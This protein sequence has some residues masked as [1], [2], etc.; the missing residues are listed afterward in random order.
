MKIPFA[1]PA[2][3]QAKVQRKRRKLFPSHVFKASKDNL[4]SSAKL[5][6]IAELIMR[7]LSEWARKRKQKT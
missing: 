7:F 4:K 1:N 6:D 2:H 5:K 3:L